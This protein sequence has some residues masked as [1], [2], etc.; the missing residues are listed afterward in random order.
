LKSIIDSGEHLLGM[1]NEL[2]DL[3]RVE[4]GKL[5]INLQP[6]DIRLF[7]QTLVAEFE[8]RARQTGL[9]FEFE[10][11]ESVPQCVETDPL[12]LR[13]ILYNLVGNA[14]KFTSAGSVF[15]KVMMF[16]PKL[17]LEIADTGKGI[18][19][20]DLPHLFKPFYQALNREQNTEGVGL[21]LYI[22]ERIV[23][24]LG[25]Q[26][27]VSS[28]PLQQTSTSCLVTS[29][30]PAFGFCTPGAVLGLSGNLTS[31]F[32]ISSFWTSKCLVWTGSRH[33]ERSR[34]AVNA[35]MFQ[36]FS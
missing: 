23:T 25:G 26:I 21:G 32:P 31:T 33:V 7:L 20:A 8:I 15:L 27:Y 4:S 16:G 18:A 2:L 9:R 12:R 5:V 34:N 19:A 36:S 10:C 29:Q 11:Q 3:A 22:T 30:R 6:A 14:F 17:R 1:M 28:V 35:R 13:Q 24:L